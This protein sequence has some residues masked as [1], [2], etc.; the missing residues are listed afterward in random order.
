MAHPFA[1]VRQGK[2][3][4]D[5]VGSLTKGYDHPD[6]PEDKALVRQ[7]VKAKALKASGGRIEGK[8]SGGRLDRY[9]RGGKVKK[10]GTNVNVI[11]APQGGAGGPPPGADASAP[12]DPAAAGQSAPMDVDSLKAEYS[13]LPPEELKMQVIQKIRQRKGLPELQL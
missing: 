3:E 10:A 12:A 1:S 4:H 2:V 6:A 7:M 8:A 9:A 11:I 5:R 13:Q